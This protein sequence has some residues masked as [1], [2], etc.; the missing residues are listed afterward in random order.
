M[1]RFTAAPR[2]QRSLKEVI[3]VDKMKRRRAMPQGLSN[4]R[5]VAEEANKENWEE[6]GSEVGNIMILWYPWSQIK[7]NLSRK[8]QR[9]QNGGKGD[10]SRH[11]HKDEQTDRYPRTEVAQEEL[12]SALKKL[13][14]SETKSLSITEQKGRRTSFIFPASSH[15]P[16][17]HC[18]EPRGRK[19]F[20]P[21]KGEWGEWQLLQPF[22]TP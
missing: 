6:R 2:L 18:S 4:V 14:H 1:L 3:Q 5:C 22:G 15:P 20:S 16:G 7:E 9:G 12:R 21:G 19:S 13:Q 10:P 17:Q 11:D 8:K